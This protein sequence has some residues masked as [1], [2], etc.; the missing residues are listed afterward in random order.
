VAL[1]APALGYLVT[2]IMWLTYSL[3][4]LW[5]I[6]TIQQ[7]DTLTLAGGLA[8]FAVVA[9]YGLIPKRISVSLRKNNV[10]P[11]LKRNVKAKSKSLI[12]SDVTIKDVKSI[13][14]PSNKKH[15]L[16][17]IVYGEG[18]NLHQTLPFKKGMI[19]KSED[20]KTFEVKNENLM[21]QK[22]FFGATKLFAIFDA[23]GKPLKI[24]GNDKKIT[25]EVL[26]LANKSTALG[27]S[28]KEMFSTNLNLKKILFFVGIGAVAIVVIVIVMG[29]GLG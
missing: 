8:V 29:G 11:T 2:Q 24:K 28:I 6:V 7:F 17:I 14:H 20:G 19:Y 22:P 26:N 18:K 3:L 5:F 15:M 27:R 16:E 25:A 12:N 10:K 1:I 23:E 21:M 4:D 9:A 13:I